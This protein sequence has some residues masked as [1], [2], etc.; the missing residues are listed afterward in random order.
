[1]IKNVVICLV[2]KNGLSF[3]FGLLHSE[4]PL[5][6]RQPLKIQDFSIFCS[7]GG[8]QNISTVDISQAAFSRPIN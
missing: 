5:A 7:I 1:M 4:L 6:R 2:I 8:F 3:V